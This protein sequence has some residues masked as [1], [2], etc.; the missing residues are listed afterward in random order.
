MSVVEDEIDALGAALR[1]QR[2][3]LALLRETAALH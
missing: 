3:Q 1:E 2:S